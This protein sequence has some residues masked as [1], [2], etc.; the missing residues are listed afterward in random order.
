MRRLAVIFAGLWVVVAFVAAG[1]GTKFNLPTENRA[2][3]PVPTNGSYAMLQTWKGLPNVKDVVITHGAGAQMF[4]LSNWGGTTGPATPR[5]DVQLYP[6]ANPAPINAPGYFTP[7]RG[8][9]NPIAIACAQ[10]DLFVLDAGDS[11]MAKYDSNPLR[12]GGP[13]C[14]AFAGRDTGLQYMD[15]VRDY[16]STWRV[17]QYRPG[18]HGGDTISTFTD[19]TFA[20]VNGIA[21][22][23][24][25]NVYVAG[26]ATVLDTS[27]YDQRIRTRTFQ[28]RIIRYTPGPRYPGINPPDLYMPGANWHR[29]TTWR[30]I[31]GTGVSYVSDPAKMTWTSG[32]GGALF[33]ADRGNNAAKVIATFAPQVG[34][35]KVDG[36]ETPTGT[37]F[38]SPEGVAVDDQGYLYVVDRLNQRV[39]RY[40][41]S[42][43]YIQQVNVENNSDGQQL[44]DPIAVGVGG[45]SLWVYIVDRG[46]G[47]VVRYQRRH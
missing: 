11:C 20:V 4:V 9:F 28:S 14:E 16:S 2:P 19:T 31:N 15:I 24:G 27:A 30:C 41:P 10:K 39:L 40:D 21:A 18:T 12:P 22:D 37:S 32:Y 47:Q 43:N 3:V 23:D 36:S 7:P 44:L 8:L 42:G 33:V 5:G 25:G 34:F 17:R 38:H 29:D 6:F 26:W 35:V 13:T 45:D 46:R 1:C